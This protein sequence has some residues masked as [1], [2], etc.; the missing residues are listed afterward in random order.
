MPGKMFG[1]GAFKQLKEMVPVIFA[2]G[3]M[4]SLVLVSNAL[5]DNLWGKLICGGSIGLCSY[6]TVCYFF[7]LEELSEMKKLIKNMIKT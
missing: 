7:K 1:Y 4:A 6:L 3:I 2:T 5:I